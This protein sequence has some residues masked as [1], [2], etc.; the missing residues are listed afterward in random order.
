MYL[1]QTVFYALSEEDIQQAYHFRSTFDIPGVYDPF[2]ALHGPE[3]VIG[4][5]LPAEVVQM[6]C[7]QQREDELGHP[8]AGSQFRDLSATAKL[9]QLAC[10]DL[11]VALPGNDWLW[12]PRVEKDLNATGT[13]PKSAPSAAY[14]VGH[15]LYPEPGKFTTNSPALLLD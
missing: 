12:A 11:K 5:L 6:Y 7:V 3:L 8:L 9:R 10:V 1:G 14:G 15:T 2:A 4:M 13:P